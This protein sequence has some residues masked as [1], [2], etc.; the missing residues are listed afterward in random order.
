MPKN[1]KDANYQELSRELDEVM[2]KLQS[3]DVDIDDAVQL[4]EQALLLIQRL[5]DHLEKA[6]NRIVELKAQFTKKEA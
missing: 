6:E 5:E 1:P 3:S 4:F 2:A